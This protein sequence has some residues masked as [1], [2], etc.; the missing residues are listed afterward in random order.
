LQNSAEE[1]S[2]SVPKLQIT[3][4]AI[5]KHESVKNFIFNLKIQN[6][7]AIKLLYDFLT[8]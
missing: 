3:K 2:V 6:L 7:L 8:Q 1:A 5:E 4:T